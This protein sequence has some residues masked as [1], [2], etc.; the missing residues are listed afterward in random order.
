MLA[1]MAAGDEPQGE[2]YSKFVTSLCYTLLSA[3]QK[4]FYYCGL[5]PTWVR[6][7]TS[8]S[9]SCVN[10]EL[11]ASVPGLALEADILIR[12]GAAVPVAVAPRVDQDPGMS[13][14]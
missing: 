5:L 10:I 4:V 2:G 6:E 12:A 13:L 11:T 3:A 9:W 7:T 1:D 14:W 8:P